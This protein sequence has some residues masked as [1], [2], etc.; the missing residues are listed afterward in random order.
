MKQINAYFANNYHLHIF[1]AWL[2]LSSLLILLLPAS[3]LSLAG[4]DAWVAQYKGLLVLG[5]ALSSA[6]FIAN[7]LLYGWN[8]VSEKRQQKAEHEKMVYMIQHLDQTEKAVLREFIIQRKNAISLPLT[9]VSVGNL[10]EAGVLVPALAS[11]EISGE[12]DFVK[13]AVNV[14][15][16]PLLNHRA[17]GIPEGKLNEQQTEWLKNARPEYFKSPF[18]FN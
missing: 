18:I 8:Q 14:Q 12:G 4:V 5:C 6:Y 16:R 11:Q 1:M 9:E 7:A 3:L 13:L 17:L 15:A 10:L 2:M